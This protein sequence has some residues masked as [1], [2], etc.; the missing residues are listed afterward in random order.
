MLNNCF[1]HTFNVVEQNPSFP[2][3][4]LWASRFSVASSYSVTGFY[5]KSS[6]VDLDSFS[7]EFVKHS[8]KVNEKQQDWNQQVQT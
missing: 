6:L 4:E 5:A 7:G 3:P 8:L 1:F 2:Q